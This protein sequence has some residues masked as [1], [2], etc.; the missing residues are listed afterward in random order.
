VVT[1]RSKG[2]LIFA[3]QL[4]DAT[5]G[6]EE[7][8]YSTLG[9]GLWKEEYVFL[10]DRRFRFDFAWPKHMIAVEIEGGT[11]VQGRHTTGVGFAKDCEKYNLAAL[12]GWSV[13]RFPTQMVNDGSAIIFM[14]KV[15][16]KL[17]GR[18]QM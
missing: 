18:W 5:F 10:K 7:K 11:Y 2:E 16:V 12:D 4:T 3:Q 8:K 14:H 9:L 1:S 13:Y 15:F 6:T 17:P